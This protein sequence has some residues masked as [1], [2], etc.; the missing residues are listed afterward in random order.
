MKRIF[1]LVLILFCGTASLTAATDNLWTGPDGADWNDSVHYWSR[2]RFPTSVDAGG[3]NAKNLIAGNTLAFADSQAVGTCWELWVQAADVENPPV[4]HMQNGT[5]NIGNHLRLGNDYGTAGRLQMEG[6]TIHIGVSGPRDL[7]IGNVGSGNMLMTGGE[8]TVSR[9][10]EVAGDLNV[11]AMTTNQSRLN[12]YGGEIRTGGFFMHDYNGRV[13]YMDMRGNARLIIAGDETAKV[14]GYIDAG[15]LYSHAGSGTFTIDYDGEIAG[16]TV[17]SVSVDSERAHSPSPA[18]GQRGIATSQSQ[19]TWEDADGAT[20]YDVYFGGNGRR[21]ELADRN[22]PEYRGRQ[23]ATSFT[24]PE[25]PAYG[26]TYFWRVDAV[27]DDADNVVGKGAVWKF[28]ATYADET[29][30]V[31][32]SG[33][34]ALDYQEKAMMLAVQGIANRKQPRVYLILNGSNDWLW[35]DWYREEYGLEYIELNSPYDLFDFDWPIQGYV[36]FDPA[37]P[38]TVNI[39]LT[40]ASTENLI[41][42]TDAIR[43]AH[44]DLP[45]WP[46]VRD[47]TTPAASPF[48]DFSAK[49][50]AQTYKW[51]YY[52]LWPACRKETIGNC[53][54]PAPSYNNFFR[55]QDILDFVVSR[56]GPVFELSSNLNAHPTE[57]TVK[58]AFLSDMPK[59]SLVMGWCTYRDSE[60]HH[61]SQCSQKNQ[62]VL[63]SNTASNFSFHQ[64]IGAQY[65]LEQPQKAEENELQLEEDKVYLSFVYSDGDSVNWVSRGAHGQQWEDR[66]AMPMTWEMQPLL[67]DIG[68]GMLEYFYR[69]ATETDTFAASAGGVGYVHPEFLTTA[70][71]EEYLTISRDYIM[72]QD[73]SGLV[74]LPKPGYPNNAVG[75]DVVDAYADILGDELTGVFEGYRFLNGTQRMENGLAWLPCRAIANPDIDTMADDL[76]AIVDNNPQRPLFIPF[77][78]TKADT[79][80]HAMKNLADKIQA[81]RPDVFK[82]VGFDEMA[83]AFDVQQ[84]DYHLWDDGED[85]NAYWISPE[86]WVGDFLPAAGRSVY[87]QLP[88]SQIQILYG[89]TGISDKEIRMEAAGEPASVLIDGGTLIA[90][91]HV[92]L[93]N[94]S[95]SR[96]HLE[97]TSGTLDITDRDLIVGNN[98]H[99]TLKIT[100]GQITLHNPHDGVHIAS[101]F[102]PDMNGTG[103]LYLWGGMIRVIGGNLGLTMRGQGQVNTNRGKTGTMDIRNDGMMILDG[104][105]RNRL[106]DYIDEGWIT[107]FGG[108]RAVRLVYNVQDD[109]TTLGAC[110]FGDLSGDC[111]VNPADMLIMARQW[112][113]D[114]CVDPDDCGKADM[115]YSGEVDIFDF[116]RLSKEW[117]L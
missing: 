93:G 6:G 35:L 41:P 76:Y 109:T 32:S 21:I 33:A 102:G 62:L 56:Q 58:E 48:V 2:T 105:H 59:W 86:N 25:G 71:L 44:P 111:V 112:L 50:R 72:G 37:I 82:L 98:G 70:N 19:I 49:N 57:Y 100:G 51:L 107:A 28:T 94:A 88:G 96:G 43:A 110:P 66:G 42:V 60:G 30:Y 87:H 24:L 92:R 20:A 31:V 63:C 67:E 106:Q 89:Q 61:V 115:N 64:H 99:G 80:Y 9:N 83:L 29:I 91:W 13:P 84:R 11:T 39:A 12:F 73:V 104:D 36:K 14:Q 77:H 46:V 34:G 79:T 117:G 3:D 47:L 101:A 78:V 113:R 90:R 116:E 1:C 4:L 26:K 81:E 68:G 18:N 74:L 22:Y 23:S 38:D 16:K 53:C 5:L 40:Y 27:I 7:C 54:V 10:F 69:T 85:G 97:M 75:Q 114:D 95:A 55:D 52:N 45:N 15:Y 17:V 8:V 103:H 108:N 65:T